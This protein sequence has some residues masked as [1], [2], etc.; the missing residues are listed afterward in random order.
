M[1]ILACKICNQFLLIIFHSTIEMGEEEEGKRKRRWQLEK[2]QLSKPQPDS[3]FLTQVH[4][5]WVLL[6]W[7][8]SL[9]T[10]LSL[11]QAVFIVAISLYL[12]QIFQPFRYL[13]FGVW[14]PYQ[15]DVL[16]HPNALLLVDKCSDLTTHCLGCFSC[17]LNPLKIFC[18]YSVLELN[19]LAWLFLDY[20]SF[21]D[22]S[23]RVEYSSLGGN[24]VNMV[25][26]SVFRTHKMRKC[27]DCSFYPLCRS[28]SR[29]S[30][31]FQAMSCCTARRRFPGL[32]I[33]L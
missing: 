10:V 7:Y 30:S 21:C 4:P 6:P 9:E 24:I 25:T 11:Q 17:I 8:W 19:V 3:G 5:C 31:L 22:C 29:H 16:L 13:H 28:S 27:R 12:L 33:T 14:K 32:P 23:P 2:V 20:F 18:N 15:T 26:Y 1:S